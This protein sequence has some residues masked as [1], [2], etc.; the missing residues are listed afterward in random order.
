MEWGDFPIPAFARGAREEAR[1]AAVP[2]PPAWQ[3][4]AA[5]LPPRDTGRDQRGLR[6]T[7]WLVLPVCKIDV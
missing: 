1:A 2:C 3:S 4:Q 5:R 6:F 7:P